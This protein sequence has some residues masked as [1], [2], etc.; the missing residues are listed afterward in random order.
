MFGFTHNQRDINWN[1]VP[2]ETFL[3]CHT[4]V[5]PGVPYHLFLF[6]SFEDISKFSTGTSFSYKK[7]SMKNH[8]MLLDY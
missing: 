6:I 4:C 3:S 5:S 2:L 1:Q 7:N 8:A